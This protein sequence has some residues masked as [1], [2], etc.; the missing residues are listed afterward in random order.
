MVI[1]NEVVAHHVVGPFVVAQRNELRMPQVVIRRLLEEFEL[2][3]EDGVSQTQA[4]ILSAVSPSPH[5]PGRAFGRR[6]DLNM[7]IKYDQD[8]ILLVTE[9]S[10]VHN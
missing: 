1:L 4:F 7:H 3:H 5:R 6:F 10:L 8:H 9:T 2:P